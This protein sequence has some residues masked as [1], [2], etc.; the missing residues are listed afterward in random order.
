MQG[1]GQARP[2]AAWEHTG[3]PGYASQL[4]GRVAFA[5]RAMDAFYEEDERIVGHAA[6]TYHRIDIRQASRHLV[7]RAR[8]PGHRRHH[9]AAGAV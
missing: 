5:W 3:L 8:R 1:G 7:V 2:R 4:K 9:P 6:D